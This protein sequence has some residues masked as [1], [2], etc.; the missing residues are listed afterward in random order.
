[1]ALGKLDSLRTLLGTRR[2]HG[3]DLVALAQPI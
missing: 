1:M 2:V 3:R